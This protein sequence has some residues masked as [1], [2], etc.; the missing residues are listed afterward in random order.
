MYDLE[1]CY[2]FM[3]WTHMSSLPKLVHFVL[4]DCYQECES[5]MVD[6]CLEHG[7]HPINTF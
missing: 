3:A 2:G 4:I 7:K 5:T 6:L 1:N